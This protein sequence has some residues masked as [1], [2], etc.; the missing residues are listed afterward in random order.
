MDIKL[1]DEFRRR[2]NASYEEA[3]YYLERCNGDLIEAIVAFEKSGRGRF[4]KNRNF[5]G[6]KSSA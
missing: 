1:I 6:R 5:H 4:Q 3:R 2:T